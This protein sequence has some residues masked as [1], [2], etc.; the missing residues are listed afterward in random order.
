[1]VEFIISFVSKRGTSL[2]NSVLIKSV[3]YKKPRCEA[4]FLCLEVTRKVVL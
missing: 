1:V 3:G 2:Q 4:G